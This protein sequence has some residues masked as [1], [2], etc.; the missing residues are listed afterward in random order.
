M[1]PGE[2]PAFLRSLSIFRGLDPP[3]LEKVAALSRFM[4]FEAGQRVFDAGG[5]CD[6]F[7]AVREGGVK[8]YRLAGDGREQVMQHIGPGRT[9]AEAALLSLGVFPVSAAA[10]ETPTVVATIRGGPFLELFREDEGLAR[11]MVAALSSRLHLLIERVEE[12]TIANAAARLARHVLKLPAKGP[13]DKPVVELPMAKKDLA[14]HLA[15]T[16]ETLSRLLRRW[17]DRGLVIS[18]RR[19]LTILDP[20]RLLAIAD[21]EDADS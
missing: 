4:T 20:Q 13:A 14:H 16:P 15:I 21:G 11:A 10:T 18:D 17:Q 7:Y 3:A 6:A 8:L 19:E 12:L 2:I 5:K 9:F 1:A